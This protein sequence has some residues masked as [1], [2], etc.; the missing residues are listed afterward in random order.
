[1]ILRNAT[2]APLVGTA[3]KPENVKSVRTFRNATAGVPVKESL[4]FLNE[5]SMSS[6]RLTML[7]GFLQ[8][9]WNYT[10]Q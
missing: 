2:D 9:V 3:T 5:Y 6:I 7:P 8:N 10:L 4:I 1:M